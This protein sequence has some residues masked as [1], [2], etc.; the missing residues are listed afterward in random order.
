[1][2]PESLI[3]FLLVVSLAG[4]LGVG[5]FLFFFRKKCEERFER[6]ASLLDSLD[7]RAIHESSAFEK[8]AEQI[9]ASIVKQQEA[10]DKE[11]VERGEIEKSL[12][13]ALEG[14]GARVEKEWIPELRAG[15]EGFRADHNRIEESMD[16]YGKKI[17]SVRFR[18]EV[19]SA[20]TLI[21]SG[22][23]D[24]AAELL[25]RLLQEDPSDREVALL[26]A[27][28]K[29]QA[30]EAEGAREV[31]HRTLEA[32]P[33][34]PDILAALAHAYW[35][36][37]KIPE[38]A[39]TLT[40]GL[41]RHP[42]HTGLLFER[43]KLNSHQKKHEAAAA[44][45]ERMLDMGIDSAEIRYNLGL[46]YMSLGKVSAAIQEL[47]QSVAI[48]PVSAESN[49]A[50]GLALLSGHRFK[51]SRDFLE[52][53]REYDPQNVPIR[54][55]LSAAY[56]VSGDPKSALDEASVAL[57]L[58]PNSG[59]A[60]LEKALA[61]HALSE[62]REA[63]EILDRF[64][65][66]HPNFI[67]AR[68]LKASILQEAGRYSESAE[69]WADLARRNPEDPNTHARWAEAL[70]KSGRPAEAL[71][72]LETA[73]KN[74]PNHPRIQYQWAKECLLQG[75][76][77]KVEGVATYIFPKVED[78]KLQAA[79]SE[80]RLLH[81]LKTAKWPSLIKIL[82]DL[83]KLAAA[84]PDLLPVDDQPGLEDEELLLLG[85]EKEIKDVHSSL[86]GFLKGDMDFED[87][88][89][90]VTKLMRSLLPA[91]PKAPP[92]P[93]PP[94]QLA[95]REPEPPSVSPHSTGEHEDV[96]TPPE[97][98][99]EAESEAEAPAEPSESEEDEGESGPVKTS[100]DSAA[101]DGSGKGRQRKRS[102]KPGR[103]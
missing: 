58:E 72:A 85:L 38:M 50:L 29:T 13:E 99:T 22:E 89:S 98:L 74:G 84:H 26:L 43:S 59:R 94:D 5:V 46:A 55:D 35:V 17:E 61:H 41:V 19:Q 36:E 71:A 82:D 47:R 97:P 57:E 23:L 93:P 28:I 30:G 8:K 27:K 86:V 25:E 80:I 79:F 2:D 48:D 1:M 90:S 34:D 65:Q 49:H 88:D 54:L 31:L 7:E 44:D 92:A 37:K 77:D 32:M 70:K 16:H 53:A 56:R 39:K 4:L 3:S 95:P 11:R 103:K 6:L 15:I 18:N 20:Y 60:A 14:W 96:G 76:Y 9:R 73:A 24:H 69:E 67:R 21:R 45:L 12:R 10:L 51:E 40:D 42:N 83:K 100:Q 52:R 102:R 78:P 64:L 101:S 75:E 87:L 91:P 63:I 81:A 66:A 62:L 68:S 33:G